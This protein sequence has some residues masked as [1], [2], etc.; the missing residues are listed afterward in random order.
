MAEKFYCKYCGNYASSVRFLTG[1]NCPR[2][3][4]GA[5]KGKHVLYEGSEKQ[6]YT[7]SMCGAKATSIRFLVNSRC[8]RHPDGAGKGF[9]TPA[10]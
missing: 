6:Q 1:S 10:L 8:P 2:H 5:G 7:C 3:P 9:H 4:D